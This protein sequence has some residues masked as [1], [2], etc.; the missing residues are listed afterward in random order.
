MMSLYLLIAPLFVF[1]AVQRSCVLVRSC[2]GMVQV[3]AVYIYI[4]NVYY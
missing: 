3:V 4:D 2:D 1:A